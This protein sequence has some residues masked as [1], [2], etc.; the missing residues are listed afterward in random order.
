MN[1]KQQKLADKCANFKPLEGRILVSPNK[2]RTYKGPGHKARP[3][4]PNISMAE[5][6]AE[7]E[8]IME[9]T[10]IDINYSN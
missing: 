3:V 8:M 5:V 10:E 9:T 4:D 1:N 2:V 7:T 6:D